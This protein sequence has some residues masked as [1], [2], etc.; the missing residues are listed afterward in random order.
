MA[1]ELEQK[2]NATVQITPGSGGVF[3]VEDNGVLIFSKHQLGRFPEE[4]EIMGI[5]QSVGAGVPLSDAKELA[6]SN[7]QQPS[8]TSKVGDWISA[9]LKGGRSD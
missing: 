9:Q 8:L 3:D 5:I 1:A 6:A 7:F 4:G 2:L